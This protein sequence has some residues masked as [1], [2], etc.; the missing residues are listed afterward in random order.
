[1]DTQA[2]GLV[3]VANRLPVQAVDDGHGGTRWDPSPG[4]LVAALAP[5]LAD[6]DGAWVGFSGCP[7]E[8]EG[9]PESWGRTRLHN[10]PIDATR[11]HDFYEGF[12]NSSLWPLYHD[13]VR[14]PEFQRE[15]WDAYV[16]VNRA[17]A[18]ACAEVADPG[19]SVWVHDYQLQL[20]PAMLRELRHDVR[21]GFFLHIPF[22]PQELFMQIPWR[23]QVV[24]GLMGADV[25]GFQVP[26]A[27]QNFVRLAQRLVGASGNGRP[28]YSGQRAL[29]VA[30]FPI[31]IDTPSIEEAARDES[32]RARAV[33]LRQELGSPKALLLGVD[34]LD[35]TK[36]IDLRLRAVE[37]LFR[38]G[39]L[40]VPDH[41][42][43]QVA[44]PSRQGV[45]TY[46]DER[47]RVE[48][49]VGEINGDFGEVGHPAVHYLH[50]TLPFDELVAMYMAADVMLV[51][52]LRDGMNLVAKEF[53]AASTQRPGRLVLSEFAGAAKELRAAIL[54]NPHDI[55]GTKAAILSALD[56]DDVDARSRLE[57]M[58]RHVRHHDVHAWAESFLAALD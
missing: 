44:V 58:Q 51:T 43:L 2:R 50:R 8:A 30:S 54:V 41:V 57:R 9:L 10:V 56:M 18:E 35:Y 37:E 38:D 53:V 26:V 17:Y 22:P 52:P 40:V 7:G 29:Q 48:R 42:M 55:D 12:S 4:G 20:V 47:E 13:A 23:R 5:V 11:Y 25:I 14:P 34:R 15:W 3:V 19:A 1:V 27:A 39:D 33:S 49:R 21:I 31:S 36:G 6:R 16:D 46:A 45:E 32:V 28:L 24:E